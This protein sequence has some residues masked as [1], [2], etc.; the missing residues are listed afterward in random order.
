MER[1][2]EIKGGKYPIVLE[3]ICIRNISNMD[4]AIS[5]KYPC[6]TGFRYTI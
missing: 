5:L 6:F 3:S 4:T 2:K 1:V